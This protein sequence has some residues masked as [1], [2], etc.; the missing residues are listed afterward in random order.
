MKENANDFIFGF[1]DKE[2]IG[3]V[4][5][6]EF[7]ESLD[8]D[9]LSEKISFWLGLDRRGYN[10]MVT[11][12]QENKDVVNI[13]ENLGYKYKN[14][15]FSDVAVLAAESDISCVNLSVGYDMEHT[16]FESLNLHHMKN[17][18]NKIKELP[19]KSW[20]IKYNVLKKIKKDKKMLDLYL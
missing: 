11:Y 20:N 2:E 3:C 12:N 5:S 18:M 19:S 8:F 15:S 17:T 7:T 6:R 9:I 10:D 16:K 14:G 13:F 1:F 4:G